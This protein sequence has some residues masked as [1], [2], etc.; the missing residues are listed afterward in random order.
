MKIINNENSQVL[1]E[2]KICLKRIQ[3]CN[4]FIIKAKNIL[5]LFSGILEEKKQDRKIQKFFKLAELLNELKYKEIKS[6]INN[7]EVI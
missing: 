7:N 5:D 2:Y 6:N 1:D 4:K 3:Y